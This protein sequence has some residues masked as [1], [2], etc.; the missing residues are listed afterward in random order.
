MNGI[1]PRLQ[2]GCMNMCMYGTVV[3]S[4]VILRSRLYSGWIPSGQY[5]GESKPGIPTHR[6]SL[7][8][9]WIL[10]K[11]FRRAIVSLI[12][13]ALWELYFI[14][15][16]VKIGYVFSTVCTQWHTWVPQLPTRLEISVVRHC[17]AFPWTC[18]VTASFS[19]L[20][21]IVCRLPLSMQMYHLLSMRGTAAAGYSLNVSQAYK[22]PCA[23][24]YI[25]W[26]AVSSFIL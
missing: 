20:R 22:H 11:N 24:T 26:S 9:H 21:V 3:P 16:A 19:A 5:P 4:S 1:S 12:N 18:L 2:F 25:H 10:N 8:H 23:W 7:T 17:E 14:C 15:E 13:F 6:K